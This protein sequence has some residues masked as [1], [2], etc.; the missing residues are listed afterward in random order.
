MFKIFITSD[1]PRSLSRDLRLVTKFSKA[2]ITHANSLHLQRSSCDEI[3]AYLKNNNFE[4]IITKSKQFCASPEIEGPKILCLNGNI[5]KVSLNKVIL[6]HSKE[7]LTFV[8][9][10]DR[11]LF[12]GQDVKI[13]A[14]LQSIAHVG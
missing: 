12:L 7:I 3:Q 6:L 9:S 14:L 1:L 10:Q 5:G 8:Q 2:K 4:L 13:V 11:V